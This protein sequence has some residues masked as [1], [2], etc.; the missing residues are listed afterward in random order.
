MAS[1]TEAEM[2][3]LFENF[4]KAIYMRTAA[5]AEMGHQQPPTPVATYNTA[6]NSI[7]NGTAKQKRSRAI[8]MIFYWVRDRIRKNHFHIFWE[9]GNKNLSDYVTKHHP[10]WYHIAMRPRYVKTTTKYI[11]NSKYRR[12][13]TGRGCAGTTNPGR[14]R[15]QGNPLKGIR[16][17]IPQ[18]P[19]NPLKGIRY[20]VQNGTRIQWPIGLTIPT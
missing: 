2:G 6:A 15:K 13:G 8:D 12:T 1:D 11:E 19:D 5:L 17:Q 7:V 16:D 3:G 20:L 10:I 18:D 4:W 9:D 14:T